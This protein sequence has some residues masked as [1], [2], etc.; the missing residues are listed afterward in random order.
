MAVRSDINSIYGSDH[1]WSIPGGGIAATEY[2]NSTW[3]HMVMGRNKKIR[4]TVNASKPVAPFWPNAVNFMHWKI[5]ASAVF[6]NCLFP[7]QL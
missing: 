4:S 7:L 5:L 1:D 2:R 6:A 3:E